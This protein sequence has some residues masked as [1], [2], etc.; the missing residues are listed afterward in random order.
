LN[1]GFASRMVV[2]CPVDDGGP[3][4]IK[5]SLK[6]ARPRQGVAML[7]RTV[8]LESVARHERLFLKTPPPRV[9]QFSERVPILLWPD[10]DRPPGWGGV[11]RFA[12]DSRPLGNVASIAIKI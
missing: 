5:R 11:S 8:F 2:A 3:P 6:L 1:S 7:T 9:A 4:M 10:H 12:N